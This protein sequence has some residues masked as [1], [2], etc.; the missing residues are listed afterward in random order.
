MNC[1]EAIEYIHSLEHFGIVPGLER[2]GELCEKL[3]NPQNDVKFIH[4]AGTN[5]KGSTSTMIANVLKEAGYNVGLYTSPYVIDFRE[6]I[7]RNG[8]MIEP[9]K[10]ALCVEK[11]K[12]VSEKYDIKATEFE[13]ITAAAFL[14]FSITKC[15]YAV[16][17]VGL[18]GRFDA[19]NIITSPEVAVI[20]CISKDHTAILGD[21]VSQI[22]FEKCGIIKQNGKVVSYPLQTEEAFSVIRDTCKQRNASLSVP[23]INSLKIISTS[24]LGT[25]A[26]YKDISYTLKLAGEHIVYNSLCAIEALKALDIDLSNETI[27]AG[28]CAT[29]MPARMELISQ[30]PLIILDG[31]HNEDCGRALKKYAE[32]NFTDKRI[33]MMSSIMA[34]KDYDAYL[35]LV[36]PLADAFVAT[37]ADVPR[38]LESEKLAKRAGQYCNECYA[39]DNSEEALS[40]ALEIT[41]ENDVLLICGSF[42]LAGEI[43][44]DLLN[45]KEDNND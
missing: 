37:K 22:A 28:L 8:Q 40:K 38:A 15:D 31:G 25:N 13:A 6:R 36:A 2:I 39:F 21:T 19:T 10:L 44:E 43:R 11:V 23:D 29:V 5:G 14:Y 41:G 27:S 45:R 17:E 26:K 34:D 32:T 18:G 1:N 9:E 12:E 3:G 33:V 24:V 4:V 20:V 16:L 42:Y 7:Q 30:K 35:K